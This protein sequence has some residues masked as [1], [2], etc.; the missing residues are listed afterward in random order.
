MNESTARKLHPVD[1]SAETWLDYLQ[2]RTKPEWRTNEWNPE[3]LTFRGDPAN[4]LTKTYVCPT[5][6]CSTLAE[7]ENG[8]CNPCRK[9][10]P[11][12][13]RTFDQFVAEHRPHSSRHAEWG[14]FTLSNHSQT[15]QA[16]IVYALQRR[17][18]ETIVLGPDRMRGVLARIPTQ[19]VSLLDLEPEFIES[20]SKADAGFIRSIQVELRRAHAAFAKVDLTES[21]VW[22]C[23]LVGL[24]ADPSRPYT[25][26]TGVLDF[27]VIQQDWL[28]ELIKQYGRDTRPSVAEMRRTLQGTEIAS[29]T[30]ARRP[31][32]NTPT[33]LSMGDMTAI[34]EAIAAARGDSSELYS[35]THRRAVFGFWRRMLDYC[36]QAGLMED[37]PGNFAINQQFHGFPGVETDDEEG[38]RAIPEH[39]IAQLDQ[40]LHLLTSNYSRG[41]WTSEDFAEMYRTSYQVL[42][43]TGRRPGEVAALKR[44]CLEFTDGK[45]VLIYDNRKRRRYGRRLP[46]SEST[47]R[48][49]QSWLDRLD[50][51]PPVEGCEQWMFPQPGG[52]NRRR[53]THMTSAHL[54]SKVFVAWLA[55]IP[56]LT[57]IG[58]SEDG[59]P[60]LFDKSEVTPY[61]FR[62]CYAQRHADAGT[63]VDV[64]REL[65]DHRSVETTM[66]YYQVSL[67]RKREAISTISR[68]IFD[69]NGNAMGYDDPLTYERETVAVPFGG[70]TEKNNV[71]AGGGHCPIRFQCAGCSFYR[72]DPSYLPAID[73]HVSELRGDREMA[74][75]SDV[76]DWVL[77]NIDSQITAFNGVGDT[78]RHTL[79]GL[80]EEQQRAVEDAARELRKA[81]Q[82]AAFFPIETLTRQPQS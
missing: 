48:I 82:A 77:D 5:V 73:Q 58:L 61:V 75:A 9:A 52:R 18:E 16:E 32:G 24:R 70:C 39:V 35:I 4:S 41:S 65:M 80:P 31:H 74:I 14:W 67:E 33:R 8:F 6:S 79:A 62:H 46:I 37:V 66:G 30:L 54:G 26:V 78:M 29:Q 49:I 10:F 56:Q 64:L 3:S 63:P 71:K 57:D 13:R 76:D 1:S 38:G 42:R 50:A 60:R 20:R 69:R 53:R 28:R 51:L 36:R 68:L 2:S 27:T 15:L 47:A 21:D 72:P 25:A 44:T 23:A 11:R 34:F 59:A 81:R 45:P 19:T 43:D 40:H 7:V 22:D 17:D 55:A 12:S